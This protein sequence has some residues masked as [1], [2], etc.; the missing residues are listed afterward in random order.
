MKHIHEQLSAYIDNELTDDERSAVENHLHRCE[1][2]QKEYEDLIFV[3]EQLKD[4]YYDLS[5]TNR[6]E[7]IVLQEINKKEE[8]LNTLLLKLSWIYVGLAGVS[9]LFI[10]AYY[11]TFSMVLNVASSIYT[12]SLSIYR[13]IPILMSKIPYLNGMIMM[14]TV[15][16]LVISIWSLRR[17]L[18][19]KPIGEGVGNV[20]HTKT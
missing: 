3:S 20:A 13:A 1:A 18:Y 10:Y 7:T 11:S 15:L 17:L 6:M 16:I 19:I 12:I 8:Q 4:V 2:C 5:T 14:F 9:F